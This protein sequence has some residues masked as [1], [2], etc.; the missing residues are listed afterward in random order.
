MTTYDNIRVGAESTGGRCYVIDPIWPR[1]TSL[2]AVAQ[3]AIDDLGLVAGLEHRPEELSTGTRRMA[4]IART[5]ASAPRVLLLDEPGAG[6][7]ATEK[8]ELLHLVR[9]LADSWGLAVL[10]I[11]HDVQ[12]VTTVSDRVLA[13]ALGQVIASGTPAQVMASDEVITSY[14]GGTVP[15]GFDVPVTE[16]EAMA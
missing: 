11:E 16:G 14:L 10:L 12:F 1:T 13:L 15:G 4:G 8:Q 5:L 9:H 3:A 6:L 2:P 7:N